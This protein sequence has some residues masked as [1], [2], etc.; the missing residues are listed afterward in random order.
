MNHDLKSQC[1]TLAKEVEAIETPIEARDIELMQEFNILHRLE[2]QVAVVRQM[3]IADEAKF[4]IV[5]ALTGQRE[6]IVLQIKRA[7]L[8]TARIELELGGDDSE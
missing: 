5:Q 1:C 2:G 4:L 8:R 6:R 7:Q 3:H